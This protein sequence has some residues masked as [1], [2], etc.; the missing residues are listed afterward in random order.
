MLPVE[1]ASVPLDDFDIV[2]SEIGLKL[3]GQF[4]LDLAV[5]LEELVFHPSQPPVFAVQLGQSF[6]E[7]D[8]SVVVGVEGLDDNVVGA[9]VAKVLGDDLDD[10][11]LAA[12]EARVLVKRQAELDGVALAERPVADNHFDAVHGR[13]TFSVGADQVVLG[14]TNLL[15]QRDANKLL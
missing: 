15:L 10:A 14:P 8:D 6:V 9:G 4:G 13:E 3:L 7:P 1:R 5:L 12:G 2:Q 11:N